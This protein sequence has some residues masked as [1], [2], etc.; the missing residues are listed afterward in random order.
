M[1]FRFGIGMEPL[2]KQV[3]LPEEKTKGYQRAY[4]GIF[5]G[6][7]LGLISDSEYDKILRRLVKK[8]AALKEREINKEA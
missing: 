5:G 1:E 2:Y 6:H 7:V 3:G 8:L 4:D